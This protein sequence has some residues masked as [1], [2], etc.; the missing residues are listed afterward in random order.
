MAREHIAVII[1]A[2]IIYAPIAEVG[3]RVVS[4]S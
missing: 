3:V 1:Y 2:P 4:E